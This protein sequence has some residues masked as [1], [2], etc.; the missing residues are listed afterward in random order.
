M[1][2]ILFAAVALLLFT[3][4]AYG[5][6]DVVEQA[7]DVATVAAPAVVAVP[8]DI[9]VGAALQAVVEALKGGNTTGIVAAAIFLLLGLFRWAPIKTALIKVIPMRWFS[10]LAVFLGVAWYVLTQVEALGW[11]G[12]ITQGLIAGGGAVTLYEVLVRAVGGKDSKEKAKL[13]AAMDEPDKLK[14]LLK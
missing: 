4:V 6:A 3:G 5:Q 14:E 1:R 9:D 8:A 13:M 11:W 7:A 12:A 2:R 10:V